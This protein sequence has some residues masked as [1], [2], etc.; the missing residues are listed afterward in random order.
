MNDVKHP[1]ACKTLPIIS[2]QNKKLSKKMGLVLQ[3]FNLDK[4]LF[5]TQKYIQ[6]TPTEYISRV[7][8]FFFALDKASGIHKP[9]H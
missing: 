7:K 4:I 2:C 3:V 8:N 6:P 9:S 1:L 5:D